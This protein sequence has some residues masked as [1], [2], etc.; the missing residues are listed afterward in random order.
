MGT[1]SH[2]LPQTM[3]ICRLS[4]LPLSA[5]FSTPP[6]IGVRAPN[7]DGTGGMLSAQEF[8][9]S[10]R[11]LVCGSSR[12]DPK[13]YKCDRCSAAIGLRNEQCYVSEETKKTLLEHADELS[14]LGI[15]MEQ[16]EALR[17]DVGTT[18]TRAALVI[19]CG[20]FLDHGVCVNWSPISETNCFFPKRRF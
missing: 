12:L 4:P 2:C 11:C 1:L 9:L 10:F 3:R 19:T 15:K 14:T 7:V 18:L 17:K 6:A 20:D 5:C 13:G 16:H 8:P